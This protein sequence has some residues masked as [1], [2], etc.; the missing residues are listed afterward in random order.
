MMPETLSALTC[1]LLS[2]CEGLLQHLQHLLLDVA[3]DSN[4]DDVTYRH[5]SSGRPPKSLTPTA[6]TVPTTLRT[7]S[8]STVTWILVRMT[9]RLLLQWQV[10]SWPDG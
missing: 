6:L 1:T 2:V 5:L 3:S 4:G 10:V 9:L 7:S 8:S